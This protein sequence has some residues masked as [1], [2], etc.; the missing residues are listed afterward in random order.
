MAEVTLVGTLRDAAGKPVGGRRLSILCDTQMIGETFLDASTTEVVSD[1]NGKFKAS[2]PSGANIQV[3]F[4]GG[5]RASVALPSDKDS[6][7]LDE[8]IK[9]AQ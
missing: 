5:Q 4:P 6:A 2:F 8:L 7:D 1:S 9:Q 3:L